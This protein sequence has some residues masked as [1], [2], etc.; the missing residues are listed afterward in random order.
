MNKNVSS[1]SIGAIHQKVN[2]QFVNSQKP[3][4]KKKILLRNLKKNYTRQTSSC[5][6]KQKEDQKLKRL[7]A[8]EESII[9]ELSM[10]PELDLSNRT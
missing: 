9:Q 6:L 3:L 5:R 2:H 7:A 4:L 1:N 10:I 8:V